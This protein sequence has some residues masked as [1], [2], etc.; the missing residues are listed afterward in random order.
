MKK[1]K[2]TKER[3]PN[4]KE[5]WATPEDIEA[6]LA[7]RVMLRHNVVTKLAVGIQRRGD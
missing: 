5:V 2:S 7:G 6:F 4:W 1:G 3:K